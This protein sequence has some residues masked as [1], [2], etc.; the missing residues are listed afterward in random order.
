M[1]VT[2]LSSTKNPF[3]TVAAIWKASRTKDPIFGVMHHKDNMSLFFELLNE[4]VPMMDMI[5]FIFLVE[6]I[7]ISLREQMVRHRL[8]IKFDD[9]IGIDIVP[10]ITDSTWW[11]QSMRVLNMNNFASSKEYFIPETIKN[12]A[13]AIHTYEQ[14]LLRIQET[15]ARLLS[16]DIPKEDARQ[17][18][19]LGATHRAVWKL[20]LSAIKHICSK[21]SCWIA[22]LGMWKDVIQ[23]MVSELSEIDKQFYEIITPPCIKNN[24]FEGCHFCVHNNKRIEGAGDEEMPPCPLY[25]RHLSKNMISKPDDL[26]QCGADRHW[27]CLQQKGSNLMARMIIDYAKLWN[28]DVWTGEML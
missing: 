21:R 18:I 4:D 23:G 28:R 14:I 16:L 5:E 25:L 11:M 15:Y 1:K 13:I 12:N 22:Q 7:P 26:W 9:R 20:S 6:G 17:V 10:D 27:T 3:S 2:L 24:K 8:G 19:P